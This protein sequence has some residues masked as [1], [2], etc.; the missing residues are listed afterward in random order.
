MKS[1]SPKVIALREVRHHG[2]DDWL[3]YESLSVRV[4][5]HAH[6]IPVHRHESVHQFQLIEEGP[7]TLRLDGTERPLHAPCVLQL[8]PGAVHGFVFGPGCHGRQVTIPSDDLRRTFADNPAM[9]TTLAQTLVLEQPALGDALADCVHVFDELAQEFESRLPARREALLLLSAQLA[10]WCH[11]HG[12]AE[13]QAVQRDAARDTLLQRFLALVDTHHADRWTIAGYA[14]RLDVS[15]DHLSRVC[16]ALKGMSALELLHERQYLEARRLLAYTDLR[17]GDV[18]Q[19]LGFEDSGYFSRFFNRCAGQSPAA[20]R[21][22]HAPGHATGHAPGS[23]S[24][25]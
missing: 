17:I 15:A 24:K 11:R 19:A 2:P 13:G 9:L 10:I 7:C 23:A 20:Y 6:T 14:E 8:P 12:S 3:H 5:L 22:H 16:R 25:P 21:Q 1:P 4:A 18:A